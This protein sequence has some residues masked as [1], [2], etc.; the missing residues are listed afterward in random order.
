[1]VLLISNDDGSPIR[2]GF[3]CPMKIQTSGTVDN[4]PGGVQPGWIKY[5]LYADSNE[6]WWKANSQIDGELAIFI[7]VHEMYFKGYPHHGFYES[8]GNMDTVA[9]GA[10]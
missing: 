3:R 10:C 9:G 4:S 8:D 2:F 7:R 5:N 1:M 6:S